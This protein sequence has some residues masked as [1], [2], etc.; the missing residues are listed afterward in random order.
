MLYLIR[1]PLWL[2]GWVAL[3]GAFVFQA[4][5]LH[6]GLVSIVQ[7]LLATELV[8]SIGLS[9]WLF[10]EHFTSNGAVLALAAVAFAVMCAGVVLLTQTAPAT[11][12]ADIGDDREESSPLG[13]RHT[14][15]A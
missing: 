2:F 14:E 7:P 15:T 13:G 11:M 4:L 1:N 6:D 9:I 10:G 5:A 8:V 12:K 3:A